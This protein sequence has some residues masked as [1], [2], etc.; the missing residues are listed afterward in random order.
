VTI[1]STSLAFIVVRVSVNCNVCGSTY[2]H[3][4]NY[5]NK[6]SLSFS[7]YYLW[8]IDW[9]IDWFIDSLIHWFIDSFIHWFID[10]LIHWFI[11]SFIPFTIQNITIH[12]TSYIKW[13]F[14]LILWR[15]TRMYLHGEINK[16]RLRKKGTE[17]IIILNKYIKYIW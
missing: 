6:N 12:F 17:E 9:F 14:K 16:E 11:H 3:L 13:V 2:F 5:Y 1:N 15:Y 10:S 7:R 8:L 4:G